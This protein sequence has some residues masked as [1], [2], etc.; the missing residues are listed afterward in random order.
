MLFWLSISVAFAQ[1]FDDAFEEEDTSSEEMNEAEQAEIELISKLED[2]KE[3]PET[4]ECQ[5]FFIQYGEDLGV[6]LEQYVLPEESENDEPI[7]QTISQS[8][9][10]ETD[11]S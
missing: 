6:D 2:C 4:N 3:T 10:D 11:D 7:E 5:E 9:E 8:L 1:G